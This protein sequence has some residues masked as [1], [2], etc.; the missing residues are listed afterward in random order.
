[1]KVHFLKLNNDKTD[2]IEIGI[3]QNFVSSLSVSGFDV[4]PKEKAKNLGFVFDDQLSLEQQLTAVTKKC[5]MNLRN[6][7]RIGSK[8]SMDLKNSLSM[9]EFFQL[10]IIVMQC[11]G[12]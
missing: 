5:N 10:L 4:V 11:M 1:M 7:W 3:Y 6:Y 8:L 2:V 9:E 12:D